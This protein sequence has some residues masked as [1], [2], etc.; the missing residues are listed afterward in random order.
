M[1]HS[2][3]LRMAVATATVVTLIIVLRAFASQ[4]YAYYSLK[5]QQQNHQDSL[6]RLVAEQLDEKIENRAS[7]LRHIAQQLAPALG[8][9]PSELKRI[10]TQMPDLPETFNAVFMAGPNGAMIFSTAVPEGVHINLGDRDY[11]RAIVNGAPFAVS[12]LLQGKLTKSPGVVLAVPLHGPGGELRAVVGGVI[13]LS[14][15][16]FLHELARSP[17]G[18]TGSFC[19]V[20]AGPN[21]RYAMHPDPSKLLAS[22]RAIGETCGV[23][24]P[25]SFWEPI[26]P[27]QPVIARYLLES[28]GWELVSVLP[29]KEAYAPLFSARPRVLAIAA[30]SLVVAAA[31][32]WLVMWRLLAPL[33]RLHRA[34]R[35]VAT[36]PAAAA[37]LPVGREDE[38]GE[39]SATF[40]D[41]MRQLSER[42]AALKTAKDH[43]AESEKRIE[44]IANHVPDFVSFIDMNERFVFVNQAYARHFGLPAQQ[45]IG[46][47]L[48]ELW[49]TQAYLASRPHLEQAFAG[50]AVKFTRES[51][52]GSECM[53]FTCQPAW[54]DA[55]D[56]ILGLHLFARNVTSERQKLRSLEAQTVS[57]HLTG[58][59]NRKGFDRRFAEALARADASGQAAALLLVDL[60]DFKAVNDGYGHAIGDRLLVALA[61]RLTCSVR[62]DD[63]VARIGGDEFAVILE[64][65]NDVRAVERIANT[66]V[67]TALAPVV[68][69]GQE[70]AATVSVGSAIHRPGEGMS[71]SELFMRADMALY[72]AKRQ[73]KAR[74]AAPLEDTPA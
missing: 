48:R 34:V 46:L 45:I 20:S 27:R 43:A 51:P 33:Q 61:Q 62:E 56:T 1:R 25:E 21:P 13:N 14:L 73:G 44:A 7:V 41:V 37:E 31:L 72:E 18:V 9:R 39:L 26:R 58:L 60:D 4:Y 6:V 57:D 70:H 53:Q 64:N 19:L 49:G 35:R 38:I 17:A 52:D 50:K 59:L 3:K 22:A 10:A 23:D 66:I 28:N 54:N 71:V 36:N 47:S 11:F 32:M 55:Q 24:Q 67:Q 69:D 15:D 30:L 2:I 74:Y 29:A 12:D 65:V 40:A 68:I 5:D 16:N 42:E 8:S 63:A